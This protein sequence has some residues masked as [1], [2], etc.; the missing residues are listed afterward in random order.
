M[1]PIR[2]GVEIFSSSPVPKI[3]ELVQL[4]EELGYDSV[5][6]TDSQLVMPEL[7]TKLAACAV[8]TKR[9]TLGPGVT[10]TRTRHPTVTASAL[11]T[12]ADLAP[13]R[14]AA[15]ISV[16][17]SSHFSLGWKPDRLADFRRNFE[18][19]QGLLQ[20]GAVSS[21][22]RELKLVWADPERTRQ[23]DLYVHTGSGNRNQRQAGE[24]GCPVAVGVELQELPQAIQRVKEGAAAAGRLEPTSRVSW[25]VSL[26]VS[27]DW[28][29][30]KGHMVGNLGTVFR[31]RYQRFLNGDLQ[32]DELGIDVEVARRVYEA[33]DYAEHGVSM[34]RHAQILMEQPDET[35]RGWL[36]GRLVGTPEEVLGRLRQA[37]QHDE[38]FEVVFT[39][40]LPTEEL[41]AS[42]LE[43]VAKQV[44]PFVAND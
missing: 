25:W 28:E 16:G 29:A 39:P 4:A 38:V 9:I 26:S 7:Y 14:V 31:R 34:P 23:I 21:D 12:L 3:V 10:N 24:M 30:I 22:G 6:L 19:I 17:G 11:A 2:F 20:G 43:T 18:L 40:H 41:M 15:A 35:W 32:A 5:W 44:R 42:A 33:Y 13:G 37:L 36:Q 27:D 8:N 1:A